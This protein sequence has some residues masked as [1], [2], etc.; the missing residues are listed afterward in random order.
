M[1]TSGT[2]SLDIKRFFET[3]GEENDELALGY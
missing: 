2:G 3:G 1:E